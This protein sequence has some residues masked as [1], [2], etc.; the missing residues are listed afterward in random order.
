MLFRSYWDGILGYDSRFS[1]VCDFADLLA[2]DPTLAPD[3]LEELATHRHPREWAAESYAAAKAHAYLDGKLT[4]IPYAG[5][6]GKS[7]APDKVPVVSTFDGAASRTLARRR[8]VLAG[9]RLAESLKSA[10]GP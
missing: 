6:E 7:I 2:R 8:I 10:L 9:N 5:V 1:S 4:L 3:K